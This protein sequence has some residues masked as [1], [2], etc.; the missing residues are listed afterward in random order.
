L[1]NRRLTGSSALGIDHVATAFGVT[2]LAARARSTHYNVCP[3]R[4]ATLASGPR[5]PSVGIG[6]TKITRRS[7][8]T[9]QPLGDRCK[10]RKDSRTPTDDLAHLVVTNITATPMSR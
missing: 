8:A 4:T 9:L 1:G 6:F 5:I 2:C 10:K 3:G 7:A